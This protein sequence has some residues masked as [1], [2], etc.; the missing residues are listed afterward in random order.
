[1]E[2]EGRLPIRKEIETIISE[3]YSR[4]EPEREWVIY[5]SPKFIQALEDA[6]TEELKRLTNTQ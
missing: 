6:I 5:G 4:K 1:M 2:I 3:I